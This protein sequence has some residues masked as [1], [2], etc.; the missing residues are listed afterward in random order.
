MGDRDGS[1]WGGGLGRGLLNLLLIGLWL[2]LF[3]PSLEHVAGL[4]AEDHLRSSAWALGLAGLLVLR[5]ARIGGI[6]PRLDAPLRGRSGPV[7]LLVGATVG[8]LVDARWV[9]VRILGDGLMGLSAYGLLGLWM[10]PRRW[11]Q[12][13][14]AAM[15]LILALP[16]GHHLETFLGYPLRVATAR[17]VQGMLAAAG[18]QGIELDTILVFDGG[19]AQVDLPCSG[20]RSLWTGALFLTAATWIERRRLGWAWLLAAATLAGL[21]VLANLLRVGLLVLAGS[22]AGLPRLAEMMHLPLGLLAFGLS[23]GVALALLRRSPSL[24][25][26]AWSPAGGRQEE[27]ARHQHEPRGSSLGTPGSSWGTSRVP[28]RAVGLGV[29]AFLAL[30]IAM[31]TPRPMVS[32]GPGDMAAQWPF[33]AALDARPLPM[34]EQALGWLAEDGADVIMRARFEHQGLSGSVLLVGSSTWRAHHQPERC[35]EVFGLEARRSRTLLVE[36][37]DGA[38]PRRGAW[39]LRIVELT[40][41]GGAERSAGYWFQSAS[42]VTD[43]HASRIWADLP[44]RRERWVM[45]S[46]L[47]DGEAADGDPTLPSL[48]RQLYEAADA[49]LNPEHPETT[50]EGSGVNDAS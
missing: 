43:D 25:K 18:Q 36:W 13:A 7:L 24:G 27:P 39:P 28:E 49:L 33:P 38:E 32:A 14:A 41:A 15:L 34:D 48:H 26:D 23:C 10:L 12:G 2:A 6:R 31:Y 21:L 37:P 4:T 3:R 47:F 17:A 30:G 9:D 19:A 22:V 8:W 42:R 46:I 20:V 44:P 5:Q 1:R 50:R 35:L 16:I 40:D 29:A 11:R 45:V